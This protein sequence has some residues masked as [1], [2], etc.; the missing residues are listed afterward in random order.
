MGGNLGRRL[1]QAL[2]MQAAIVCLLLDCEMARG[3]VPQR[4]A[5]S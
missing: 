5:P 3:H 1:L 2:L 4:P